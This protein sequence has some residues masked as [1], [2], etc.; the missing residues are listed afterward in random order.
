MTAIAAFAA[1]AAHFLGAAERF[2]GLGSPFNAHLSAAVAD[3]PE[4]LA[5]AAEAAPGQV[6]AFMLLGAVHDLLLARPD[7]ELAAYYPS[8]AAEP[9][10]REG[11]FPAF[12]TFCREHGHAVAERVRTRRMQMTTAGRAALLLPA[13]VHVADATGEPLAILEIGASAGVLTLF[14]RYCYE[15][16][17][18]TLGDPRAPRISGCAFAGAPP[19]RLPIVGRR[20]GVD[21]APIDPNDPRA[22]RWLMA[23]LPPDW[24]REREALRAC[25]D[26]RAATPLEVLAGDA[27][28]LVPQMLAGTDDPVCV[29]HANCLYQWPGPQVQALEEALREASRGRVLHRLGLEL[30]GPRSA[31]VPERARLPGAPPLTYEIL[32]TTYRDG[33]RRARR[34]AVHDGFGRRG[35]WLA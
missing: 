10:A 16:G 17:A 2:R 23:L 7:L 13:M 31:P 20:A 19:P 24:T 6:P 32:H 25:L 15:T 26:L 4:L 28:E 3:D 34:L 35:V 22:R 14:D 9:R 11:L 1:L 8:I 21:L 29:F 5:L 12:Q 33:E 27:L 30:L 18:G